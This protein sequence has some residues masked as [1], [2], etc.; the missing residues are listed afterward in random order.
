MKEILITELLKINKKKIQLIDIR[1]PYEYENGNLDCINIPM[2][3]ILAYKHKINQQK[4]VI[5]YCQSGR[6]AAAVV[7]MLKKKYGFDNILTLKGGYSAYID[8]K[9]KTT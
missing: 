7:Y 6:R 5:I 9:N 8:F 2:S 3:E 4:K 1:E